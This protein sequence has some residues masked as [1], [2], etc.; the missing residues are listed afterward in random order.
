[1]NEWVAFAFE[2][3]CMNE[4]VAFTYA[5]G[6]MNERIAFTYDA[7]GWMNDRV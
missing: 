7:Y 6:C 5:F 3:G 2:K 1:M 4:R